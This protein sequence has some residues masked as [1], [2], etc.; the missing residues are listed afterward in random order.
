M[1]PIHFS[2]QDFDGLEIVGCGPPGSACGTGCKGFWVSGS[3]F[4][5]F[6]FLGFRVM[7]VEKVLDSWV[8][9]FP[10]AARGYAVDR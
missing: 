6:F 3:G 8:W 9:R 4:M 10:E 5:A 2:K 1:T 7:S